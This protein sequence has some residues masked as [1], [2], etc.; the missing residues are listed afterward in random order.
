MR[1][2]KSL[3]RCW[4]KRVNELACHTAEKKGLPYHFFPRPKPVEE[5][6]IFYRIDSSKAAFRHADISFAGR[7]Q[8][9]VTMRQL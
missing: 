1:F 7:S 2:W 4:P 5:H 3:E 9:T 6:F 8:P